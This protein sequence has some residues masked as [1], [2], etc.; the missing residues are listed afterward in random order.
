MVTIIVC[1]TIRYSPLTISCEKRPDSL[2]P[3]RVAPFSFATLLALASS[4]KESTGVSMLKVLVTTFFLPS[5]RGCSNDR[6]W[7]HYQLPAMHEHLLERHDQQ[8]PGDD[9]DHVEE[10]SVRIA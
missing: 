9:E 4:E 1:P 8:S 3:T 5:K 10:G 2:S 6:L 7:L